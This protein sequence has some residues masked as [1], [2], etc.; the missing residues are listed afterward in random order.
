MER[1]CWSGTATAASAAAA[2]STCAFGSARA[3]SSSRIRRPH[4]RFPSIP[5]G[6]VPRGRSPRGARRP[7][8]PGRRGH[9]SRAR[10][11]R[12]ATASLLA[13]YRLL[14]GFAA[15][16][17]WSYR[18]VAS[19]RP[20][21]AAPRGPAG[22]RPRGPSAVPPHAVRVPA[23]PGPRL[24]CGVRVARIPGPRPRR[25]ARPASGAGPAPRGARG[26]RATTAFWLAPDAGLA[27]RGRLGAVIP[28]WGGAALSIARAPGICTGAGVRA[29]LGSSICRSSNS[30]RTSSRSSGTRC[31]WR[32]GCS[33][34]CWRRGP[35]SARDDRGRAA[36]VARRRLAAAA[37]ALQ[38]DV[39]APG[40]TKLP[41]RRPDLARSHRA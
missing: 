14:P 19:H 27:G 36:A 17:E 5:R 24:S 37:A 33:P 23:A 41:E 6:V 7:R 3:S 4:V 16:S 40:L 30:V 2:R 11:P 34:C 39:P 13:A 29:L 22:R 21:F 32:R 15:L 38:A 28:G 25:R 31:S 12:A 8:Q 10:R 9:L 1:P 18:L 35:T 26:P 20:F